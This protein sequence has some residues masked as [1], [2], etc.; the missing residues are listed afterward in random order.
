[1]RHES[2]KVG[3]DPVKV[4][5]TSDG[6]IL[7]IYKTERGFAEGKQRWGTNGRKLYVMWTEWEEIE[8]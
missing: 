7:G 2:L 3:M 4:I 6:R 5:A 1:M 8:A